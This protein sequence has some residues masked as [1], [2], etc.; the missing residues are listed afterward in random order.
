MK[1]ILL[2][3]LCF[4]LFTVM[5][6]F[7]Q[8]RT[9]GGTVTSQDDGQPLPG[10]SVKVKGTTVGTQTGP[11]GRFTVK[12]PS[13]STAL[14]VSYVGYNPQEV[15]LTSSNVISIILVGDV[16]TLREI[17]VT[18]AQNIPRSE[19]SLGYAAQAVKG[20]DLTLTKQPD[21]N[22]ALAGKVSGIQ[23]SGTSG[24]NFGTSSIRIR[25]T[26][27]IG[28]GADPLYVV[29][30]VPVPSTSVN[31]DDV[32]DL[33]VLKGPAATSLYGQR[34][35]NGVVVIT[36]K[37]GNRKGFGIEFNHSTTLE[38]VATLPKY[39]NE[40]GGGASQNWSTFTYNPAVDAPA[41]QALNGQRYY[42][43]SVDESWGP[44]FDG[45][46]Y[47]PWYA[48]NKYD[49]DYGKTKPWV[50]QPDNVRQ[51][52]NTGVE[53]N[54]N[55]AFSS[56]G[57]KHNFRASYTNINR[58]GVSPN[59][60][61]DQNRISLIG[62]VKPTAKLTF[63]SSVNFNTIR[64]R[65]R[66]AE[67]YN[68]QTIGSFSQWFHRDLEIDK[69]RNYRNPDGTFTTWNITG[70]RNLAPKYWDNPF[71][72]SYENTANSNSTRVFGYLQGSY[73]IISGL[74]LD[75]IARGNYSSGF[76]DSRVASGTLNQESYSNSQSRDRE[77]NY[78]I[79]LLYN[80]S[81]GENYSLRAGLYGELR[82]NHSE[83]INGATAGGFTVPN[84]YTLGASKDRPTLTSSIINKQVRSTYGFIS[85]GYR[86]LLF[87]DL[88]LRN[89]W[90]SSLP[91]NN[92][93][94]LY[95]GASASFVFTE[96]MPKNDILSFGKIFTS[97]GRVGSDIDP[98]N[99]T[100]V[101]SSAG[102]Y[103]TFPALT[104]PNQIYNQELKPAL[105]DSYEAG[106][107]L[108]FV[109]DRIRLSFNYYNRKTT[110]QIISLTLPSTTG[111]SSAIVNAGEIDNHGYEF[112]LAGTP[113]RSK[114]FTWDINANLGINRNKIV[115]LAA[116][117]QNFQLATFGYVGT[118]SIS[119]NRQ[120]GQPFGTLLTP[121]IKTDANGNKLIG[122][123]GFPLYSSSPAEYGNLGSYIPKYTG[124]VTTT[125]NYKSFVVGVSI[126]FQRGGKLFS[127]TQGNLYGSGLAAGTVGNN[128]K[129]NP[130]RTPVA[131]GGGILIQGIRASDGKPNT[132]YVDPQDY[133]EGY[134]P[135]VWSEYTYSAS[136]VKM[137]EASIGYRL[138]ASIA[139]KISA[140]AVSLTLI[141]RNPWLI[142]TA[143]P[144]I[145]PS[146]S[147]FSWMEG[148]QL[149]GTRSIGLNLRV[150]F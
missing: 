3:N 39:Q 38:N 132:T 65:N 20:E 88:N 104:V 149:P 63:T 6:V 93:S 71:T 37:K 127:V 48:F 32:Q 120:I 131:Q 103:G 139:R 69:L 56:V 82:V 109:K 125:F 73:N 118:P 46:P 55:V 119:V 81:F 85:G 83:G 9:V 126:D 50:A 14:Q 112:T 45:Q 102:L 94:Y 42:N 78:V 141:A 80:K 24:A 66:P 84:T 21:L 16:K 68:N 29:D 111:F 95:G 27:S 75:V 91:K 92:N 77:N 128:D 61:A 108:R 110:N 11:D 133:Y 2:M 100:P 96:L 90:S 150:T 25:G 18:T 138:P 143:I 41:L 86:N 134:I 15:A 147:N 28:G 51:F 70:P 57:D 44:K 34:G 117:L 26:N 40:Y 98:Y 115:E 87:L 76:N 136:Y 58:S 97:F 145:D 79:D 10:V 22:T 137:R 12:V 19:R 114:D 1:K 8:D 101:Y 121:V 7:A 49:P 123:D 4:L 107:D 72:V 122:D 106:L 13:G 148:G 130:I 124:G 33:T 144:G 30:G 52:Y 43:Y 129:G 89:D 59:S 142:H 17:V 99:I 135:Y 105:S 5:Q 74:N 146:Q 60:R 67:G 116:G 140:Q 35:E 47:I 53:L 54:S 36:S 23:I 113:I 62:T 31:T 64:Y